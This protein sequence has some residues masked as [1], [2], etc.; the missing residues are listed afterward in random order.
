MTGYAELQVTS[1]FSFLRG[2][3]HPEELA[4]TAAALGHSAFAVTDRNSLAGVVRAHKAAREA[5][6]RFVLGVRLDLRESVSSPSP[7]EG[8]GRGGGGGGGGA[9]GAARGRRHSGAAAAGPRPAARA[10]SLRRP[11]AD[12]RGRGGGS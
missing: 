7:L 3:S 2:G 1:N 5:G 9:A 6:I 10:G 4:V 8:E 12:G 11:G